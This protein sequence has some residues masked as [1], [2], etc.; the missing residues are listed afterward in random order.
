MAIEFA[1]THI[2]GRS[3][4]HTAV[5]AA[6]Y[7]SGTDMLDNA[8]GDQVNYAHRA[9]E[10]AHSE[11][12]LP[13]GA[14]LRLADRQTLWEAAEAAENH[15]RRASAQLAKDHIIALPRELSLPEQIAM[16]RAF[17]V[18]EFVDRGV[19]VDLNVHLHSDGNPHAHL[20]TT[21]RYVDKDGFGA[22]ARELNGAFYGGRRLPEEEQLRHRWADF[23]NAWALEQGIDL[24][25]T[26]NNG[27]WASELHRGPTQHMPEEQ[28]QLGSVV[29]DIAQDRESLLLKDPLPMLDRLADK[30]AVFTRD[31]LLRELANH[32]LD[33]TK[34]AAVEQI[35]RSSNELVPLGDQRIEGKEWF[36][37]RRALDQEMA[38]TAVGERLAAGGRRAGIPNGLIEKTIEADFDFLADEQREAVEHLCGSDSRVGVVVG[39][40]GAGKSTMLAAARSA[41]ERGGRA[42]IGLA[43]A[44][45]AAEGLQAS[46]GIQ[47]QT[48]HSYLLALERG[49]VELTPGNVVVV[50]EAGMVNTSLM[51]RLTERVEQAGAKLVLVGDPEQLQPI[52]AGNPLR[53]FAQRHGYLELE[54]VRRQREA[55][56][57]EATVNL[58][59]GDVAAALTAYREH[60]AMRSHATVD[61][62]RT[63]ITEDVIDDWRTGKRDGLIVLA[64]SNDDVGAINAGVRDALVASGEVDRG[65]EFVVQGREDPDAD[66]PEAT[67]EAGD[68]VRFGEAPPSDHIA[69]GTQG[70]VIGFSK[71]RLV[72]R[73]PD[74]T[75]IKV[76][77]SDVTRVRQLA[78]PPEEAA[79]PENRKKILARFGA[80]DRIL[81]GKNDRQLDV[82]N[83]TTATVVRSR[84]G[85]VTARLDDGRIV[86]VD[87]N[88]YDA[89]SHAYATT[90]H[91]AQGVTVDRAKL[92][93]R[94]SWDKHLA[95]VGLSRH[96]DSVEIYFGATSFKRDSMQAVLGEARRQVN[97]QDFATE[98][99]L[100]LRDGRFVSPDPANVAPVAAE[101]AAPPEP[102]RPAYTGLTAGDEPEVVDH[103]DWVRKKAEEF[104]RFLDA[105]GSRAKITARLATYGLEMRDGRVHII[106]DN[107]LEQR[108]K[109]AELTLR[110]ATNAVYAELEAP[111]VA[112]RKQLEAA[113]TIAHRAKDRHQTEKPSGVLS[114]FKLP[115]W[116][117][118]ADRLLK[119][120]K[121][122]ARVLKVFEAGWDR[123]LSAVDF[124]A[125][126]KANKQNPAAVVVVK[127]WEERDLGKSAVEHAKLDKARKQAQARKR[128]SPRR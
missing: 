54:G 70:K 50:D 82:K 93:V 52:Q 125:V 86:R 43:L 101:V 15:N 17:A 11:I 127:S 20:M 115:A 96:R 90:V 13:A 73:L 84:R 21:T 106:P 44:G 128:A 126:G 99:G 16:A 34:I 113:V 116:Q 45:K 64:H 42:V 33:H 28:N 85:G 76:A 7:R 83:G 8:F 60:G 111:L 4:G 98:H 24:L 81:F 68:T 30:K 69:P 104:N 18:S 108:A 100:V 37:T 122:A 31:D 67:F 51:L 47:S 79:L 53:A 25:V 14:D 49:V 1:R 110:S 118:E 3:S 66:R 97:I 27:E 91:K 89:L 123:A 109:R 59:R 77:E 61:E 124:R 2:I 22:K 12:L 9:G 10:V 78:L 23:Q 26:N 120:V 5:K 121:E 95:Y 41:W 39:L 6:A 71:E 36:T 65:H 58:A 56:Q 112:E 46:A 74:K 87:V 19:A 38:L 29:D 117:E 63:Q 57:R 80:G 72:V 75:R 55:W 40:A 114:R 102:V 103:L 105:G 35:L 48:I 32:I 94:R 107:E 62:A 88:K 119:A 92:F